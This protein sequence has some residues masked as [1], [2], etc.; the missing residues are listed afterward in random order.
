MKKQEHIEA[1]AK[2]ISDD[3]LAALEQIPE[4]AWQAVCEIA[5][6]EHGWQE[7]G[8]EC[9]VAA[10]HETL[11]DF[12]NS[13]MN[14]WAERGKRSEVEFDNFVGRN[15]VGFQTTKGQRR[16]QMLVID[17]GDIRIALTA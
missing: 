10:T 4:A 2:Y 9:A 13:R 17:C 15:Y 16:S 11:E 7:L 8:I 5:D 14:H 3:S 1:N 12:D 6:D